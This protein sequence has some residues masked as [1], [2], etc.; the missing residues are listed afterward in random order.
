MALSNNNGLEI[1]LII[2][3][4]KQE[5]GRLN[6]MTFITELVIICSMFIWIDNFTS[7]N[8]KIIHINKP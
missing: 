3:L 8:I 1:M 5:R 7:L 2:F 4:L 6:A